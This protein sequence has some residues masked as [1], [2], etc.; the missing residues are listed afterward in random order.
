MEHDASLFLAD[1]L[2]GVVSASFASQHT[3]GGSDNSKL[4]SVDADG[5]TYANDGTTQDNLVR[6]LLL[7]GNS[8]SAA[9]GNFTLNTSTGNQS[10]TGLGFQP[11]CVIFLTGQTTDGWTTDGMR[12]SIGCATGASERWCQAFYA[13]ANNANQRYSHLST[14]SVIVELGNSPSTGAIDM[15]ADFVSFD[16]DGFT[17]NISNAG[18]ANYVAY[19][20]MDDPDGGFYAGSG[21]QKTTTGTQAYTGA[22]FEPTALYTC[23]KV[24]ASGSTYSDCT[25]WGGLSTV[26]G[27][28]TAAFGAKWNANN[29]GRHYQDKALYAADYNAGTVYGAADLDS[30]DT[31]GFTLDWTT[32]DGVGRTFLYLAMKTSTKIGVYATPGSAGYSDTTVTGVGFAPAAV[33][34]VTSRLTATGNSTE[35][36]ATMLGFGVTDYI[37]GF[38]PQIYRWVIA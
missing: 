29:T 22:G 17:I 9:A 33:M 26:D 7:G 23:G 21:T 4:T 27:A 13:V 8:L 15:E 14:S 10:V 37:A 2:G 38:I 3:V 28:S 16:T 5:W 31:D 11:S 19:L 20:A 24:N 32:T 36:F 18:R 25:G 34:A 6:Y 1:Q 30:F 35:M 12:F